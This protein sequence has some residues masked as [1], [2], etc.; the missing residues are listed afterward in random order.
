MFEE[1]RKG[2]E[3]KVNKYWARMAYKRKNG[4]FSHLPSQVQETIQKPGLS[5][6]CSIWWAFD[7]V[8]L[9]EHERQ[10]NAEQARKQRCRC[11]KDQRAHH[12]T[13]AQFVIQ[14]G[15]NRYEAGDKQ[16]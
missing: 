7:D 14:A 9:S 1:K 13:A 3:K 10:N 15:R 6:R 8:I 4:H 11:E 12:H 16:R 5:S 2:L